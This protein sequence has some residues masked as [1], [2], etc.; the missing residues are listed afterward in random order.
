MRGQ[1]GSGTPAKSMTL[2]TTSDMDSL[3]VVSSLFL[4]RCYNSQEDIELQNHKNEVQKTGEA[5]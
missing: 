1:R 2:N 5:E 4:S 3:L